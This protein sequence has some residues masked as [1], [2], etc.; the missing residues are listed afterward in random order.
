[1]KQLLL[2]AIACCAVLL[3]VQQA[4]A[5]KR[6]G[7]FAPKTKFKMVVTKVTATVN[8]GKGNKPT[9]VPSSMPQFKV[10][11]K[12]DFTIGSKGQLIGKLKKQSFSLPFIG[13]SPILNSYAFY[14]T[15]TTTLAYTGSLGKNSKKKA[16]TLELYFNRSELKIDLGAGLGGTSMETYSVL[17]ELKITK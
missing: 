17:Y 14:D 7:D 9:K 13:S 1:M 2:H 5:Q 16:S 4:S 3:P 6:Y 10:K 8:D 15:G 11:D 12:I